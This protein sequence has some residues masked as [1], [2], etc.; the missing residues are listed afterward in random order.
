MNSKPFPRDIVDGKVD[1]S[2]LIGRFD[3]S[4]IPAS[5]QEPVV[6]DP[7]GLINSKRDSVSKSKWDDYD[8]KFSLKKE[9]EFSL[10]KMSKCHQHLYH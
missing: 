4:E 3:S 1:V 5:K 6:H 8:S 2:K 9:R 10:D 7:I